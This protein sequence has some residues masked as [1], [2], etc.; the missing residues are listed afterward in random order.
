MVDHREWAQLRRLFNSTFAS[1]LHFSVAT[2]G[3][4][5]QPLVTPIGSVLLG[6]PGQAYYFEIFATGLGRRLAVDPRVSLLAVDSGKLLWLAAL[7]R[8]RF[9]RMPAVRLNGRAGPRTRMATETE[10]SRW[11]RRV[12]RVLPLRGGRLLWSQ[13]DVVRDVRVESVDRIRL[14]ALTGHA[15]GE[16]TSRMPT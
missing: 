7:A 16:Q 9:A 10:R 15:A 3:D 1:S 12:R 2:I 6:E 8:G 13:L 11:R 4:R 5:G 14:G